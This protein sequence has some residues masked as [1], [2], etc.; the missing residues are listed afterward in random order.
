MVIVAACAV[1]WS[2]WPAF[3]SA[4]DVPCWFYEATGLYCPGCGGTRAVRLLLHGQI[5][6]SL[7]SHPLVLPGAALFAVFMISQTAQRLSRGRVR[8][9]RWHDAYLWAALAVIFGNWIIK[10]ALMLALGRNI[11]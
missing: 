1:L 11:L 4:V 9:M 6:A 2:C 5:G 8:G 7:W 3:R 10:N